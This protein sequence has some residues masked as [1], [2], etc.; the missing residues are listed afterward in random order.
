MSKRSFST[1]IT[2]SSAKKARSSNQKVAW[3]KKG[4]KIYKHPKTNNN[5]C[6]LSRVAQSGNDNG[7]FF[8]IDEKAGFG[9]S[10]FGTGFNMQFSFSLSGFTCYIGGTQVAVIPMNNSS[11][12]T[13]LF[14]NYRIKYIDFDMIFS[15][16]TSSVNSP[17]TG[18]P[19]ILVA[20][21]HDDVGAVT[22]GGLMQYE[23]VRTWQA[24]N[25]N[26]R[27]NKFTIR[28]KPRPAALMF[29]G[30][31]SGYAQAGN[32]QWLDSAY[33]DIPHYGVKIAM[34][35]ATPVPAATTIIGYIQ[36]VAR[37]TLEFKGS[38]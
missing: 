16:N 1:T 6:V 5:Y 30:V 14:D 38:K 28:V 37:Y 10:T 4:Y 18:L 27:S 2:E 22:A 21:D 34:N 3:K 35:N 29:N 13:N 12:F 11:E 23:G 9:I 33:P 15:N 36:F 17:A 20:K 8:C 32:N 31:S 7:V 19:T 24:G 26:Q 25:P